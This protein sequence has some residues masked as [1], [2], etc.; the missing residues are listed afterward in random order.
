MEAVQPARPTRRKGDSVEYIE[1]VE[2]LLEQE[3][4]LGRLVAFSRVSK[5]ARNPNIQP[6]DIE[7]THRLIEQDITTFEQLIEGH[8]EAA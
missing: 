6:A 7:S 3:T 8:A 5:L 4:D 2:G 1:E